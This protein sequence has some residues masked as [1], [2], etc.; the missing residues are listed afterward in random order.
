MHSR[1]RSNN[2]SIAQ[3]LEMLADII[4]FGGLP[5]CGECGKKLLRWD[6]DKNT[7]QCCSYVTNNVRCP[8]SDRFPSRKPFVLPREYMDNAILAKYAG[9]TILP[10]GRVYSQSV[11]NNEIVVRKPQEPRARD[12]NVQRS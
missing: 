4:I 6:L 1:F 8:F 3:A 2:T 10:N 11:M 7:Y 12:G 5:R 9:K